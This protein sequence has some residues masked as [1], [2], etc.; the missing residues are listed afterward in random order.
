[1]LVKSRSSADVPFSE[2]TPEPIYRSRRDFMKAAVVGAAGAAVAGVSLAAASP[3]T[4][5]AQDPLPPAK[6]GAFNADPAVDPLNT[7]Q[8]VTSYN[9]YYEFGVDKGDPARYAKRL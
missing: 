5:P 8:Q 4:P 1:M 2:V 6:K 7:L 3:Q 9:N